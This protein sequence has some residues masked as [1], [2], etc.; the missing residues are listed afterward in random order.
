MSKK[1]NEL[2]EKHEKIVNSKEIIPK[3]ITKDGRN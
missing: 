2:K 3:K 1:F